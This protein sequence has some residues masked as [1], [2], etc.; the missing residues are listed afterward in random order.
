MVV[1]VDVVWGDAKEMGK[2]GIGSIVL[3]GVG[4]VGFRETWVTGGF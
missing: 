1:D 4:G 3:V 2:G